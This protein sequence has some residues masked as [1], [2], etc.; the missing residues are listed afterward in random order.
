MSQSRSS[1]FRVLMKAEVSGIERTA[2]LGMGRVGAD[3]AEL[4]KARL[5]ALVVLTTWL[6][7]GMGRVAQAPPG[8]LGWVLLGTALLAGGAAV[9]NQVMERDLDALMERT[10]HRPLAAGRMDWRRAMVGG[11]A[12]A[13]TGLLLLAWQVNLLTAALGTIT[14]IVYLAVYT[15]LKRRTP[16]NTWI[17]AVPGALPPVMGWAASRGELGW[18]AW[19]LFLVQFF[20]QLP[21]FWAIA[22]LYRKDYA[23]AGLKMLTVMDPDGRRTATQAVGNT[24]FLVAVSLL[25][26]A[27]GLAGPL[28][29]VVAVLAGTG[30]SW[31]AWRFARERTDQAARWLFLGSIAYLPLVLGMMVAARTG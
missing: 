22:W 5:T 16:A 9:L 23:R 13:A 4:V 21:H 25:P 29:G 27:A 24:V 12:A 17:G 15:P 2:V 14:L 11:V 20:W 31:L 1:R 10:R 28:Y 7:Y 30:F 3:L 18:G 19:A 6:G 8:P 26:V